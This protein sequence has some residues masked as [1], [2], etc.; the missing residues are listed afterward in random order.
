LSTRASIAL[1][2]G[3]CTACATPAL[4]PPKPLSVR[5]G[6]EMLPSCA[7]AAEAWLGP[8][9][10]DAPSEGPIAIGDRV[11]FAL[12]LATDARLRQWL[13][14]LEAKKQVDG[15]EQCTLTLTATDGRR[16]TLRSGAT[17]VMVAVRGPFEVGSSA[18]VESREEIARVP[19]AFLKEGVDGACEVGMRMTRA[20]SAPSSEPQASDADMR[21]FCGGIGALYA[22]LQVVQNNHVLRSILYEVVE[23]PSLLS[24]VLAGF[25]VS[26]GIEPHFPLIEP[27]AD[28]LPGVGRGYRLPIDLALNGAPALR[29]ELLVVR[30]LSPLHI[31]GGIIALR[32]THPTR[33]EHRFAVWLISA[34]RS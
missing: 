8:A 12:E 7:A 25:S 4:G 24:I 1:A 6:G 13:L 22:F 18:P 21:T 20:A 15:G 5:V 10:I 3:L 19:T 17:E 31:C 11:A 16:F 23:K 28:P 29:M 14:L 9:R 27:I 30:P 33:E 26:L 32:A 2:L 34:R